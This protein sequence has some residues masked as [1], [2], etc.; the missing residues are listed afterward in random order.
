MIH[1]AL[2]MALG[3][4]V[5]LLGSAIGLGGGFVVVPFLVLATTLPH[6]QAVA[7]SLV[8]VLATAI[9]STTGYLR[10]KRLD[11]QTAAILA[12]ASM[13]GAVAGALVTLGVS[14]ELFKLLLAVMLLLAAA[15]L[16]VPPRA[17]SD[18]PRVVRNGFGFLQRTYRTLDGQEVVYSVNLWVGVVAAMVFG[19]V[20]GFFG[21]GGGA[22]YV[23]FM[24]L[25]MGVPFRVAV[26]ISSALLIP[27][28][29]VALA[30]L[31]WRGTLPQEPAPWLAAGAFVGAIAG[32]TVTKRMTGYA[33]RRV[34]AV[35]LAGVA[36]TMALKYFGYL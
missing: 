12:V 5:G 6:P 31:G 29:A 18:R 14:G 34:M 25:V 33:L 27:Q 3:V 26:P 17:E 7:T 9:V 21:I 19:S 32:V 28:S 23:P 13:P 10:Q 15:V 11:A 22:L 16:L 8:V 30:A 1:P 2:L 36:G 24:F 20:A 35:V 4:F